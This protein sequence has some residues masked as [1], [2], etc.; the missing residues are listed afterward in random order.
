MEYLQL[1]NNQFSG[2]LPE[3]VGNLSNLRQLSLERS[4]FTGRIPRSM[5]SMTRLEIA[6][7]QFNNLEGAIPAEL[8]D[9]LVLEDLRADCDR[10]GKVKCR[11]CTQCCT[12]KPREKCKVE[13]Q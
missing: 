12:M 1:Q 10:G 5:R 6:H 13:D 11:C 2:T 9:S 8:C 3:D 4:G 7:L